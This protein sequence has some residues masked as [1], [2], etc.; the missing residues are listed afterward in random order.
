MQTQLKI[1]LKIFLVFL[2]VAVARLTSEADCAA[3]TENGAE[4]DFSSIQNFDFDW[5][6]IEAMV[7][8]EFDHFV[9][10]KKQQFLE[11]GTCSKTAEVYL[12]EVSERRE[13]ETEETESVLETCQLA[14]QLDIE[15]TIENKI[16]LGHLENSREIKEKSILTIKKQKSNQKIEKINFKLELT[17]STTTTE[18]YLQVLLII[19]FLKLPG[20]GVT[21]AEIVRL[22]K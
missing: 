2:A 7:A 16:H 14:D 3:T 19:L 6:T 17:T 18:K 10:M 15:S 1:F 9:E 20:E 12:V 11:E 8:L 4:I 5:E 13:S 21:N 22:K